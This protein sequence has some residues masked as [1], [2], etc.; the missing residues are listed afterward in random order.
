MYFFNVMDYELSGKDQIIVVAC[1]LLFIQ[2]TA[3][4]SGVTFTEFV[5]LVPKCQKCHA[6]Y[7]KLSFQLS[8]RLNS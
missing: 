7:V 3:V 6:D 1:S 4:V 5:V 8:A 2:A